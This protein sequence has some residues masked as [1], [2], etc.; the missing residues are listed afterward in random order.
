MDN[1]VVVIHGKVKPGKT[2]LF[3]EYMKKD[4]I[5][6]K[7]QQELEKEMNMFKE[8]VPKS[9]YSKDLSMDEL[10]EILKC[11]SKVKPEQQSKVKPEQQSKVKP[12]QQ[13]KVKPE[14]QS[15]VKPE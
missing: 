13:S 6:F 9:A 14:Q 5:D 4:F 15:K 8:I 12:E 10:D 11:Q 1:S 7:K 3:K 2:S